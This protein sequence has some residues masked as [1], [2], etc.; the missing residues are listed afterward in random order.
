M[1]DMEGKVAGAYRRTRADYIAQGVM[2]TSELGDEKLAR[3]ALEACHFDE[4]VTALKSTQWFLMG[5]AR[6]DPQERE[7]V[8]EITAALAKVEASDA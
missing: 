3:A 1:G 5:K 2:D 7:I 6:R 8:A 4:L